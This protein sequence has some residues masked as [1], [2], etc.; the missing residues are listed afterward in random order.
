MR[1]WLK[2][3]NVVGYQMVWLCCVAGA[4]QGVAWLGPV[5]SLVFVLGMLAFGGKARDDLRL[6]VLALPVGFAL[7]SAFAYSGWLRYAQA[8]PWVDAAPL[9]IWAVWAAFAMTI[10]HS[11]AFLRYRPG[12]SA[13][14]GFVGGPLAYFSAAGAFDAVDFIAPVPWVIA[15]LA[16]GWALALP[17][18]FWID[19]FLSR[20]KRAQ[21]HS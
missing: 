1:L 10:N 9:W 16:I 4:G 11:M 3:A 17:S 2:I 5:A 19:T 12:L 6:L 18:T 14:L 20:H 13:L 8:W 7:D 21:A 15:A